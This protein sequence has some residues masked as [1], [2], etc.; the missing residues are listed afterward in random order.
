MLSP[1]KYY[2]RDIKNFLKDKSLSRFIILDHT[3]STTQD[4][5]KLIK[6]SKSDDK[7]V[8]V[9]SFNFLW[10]PL[11]T[12]ATNLGLRK[13]DNVEPNWLTKDDI[14]NLFYLENFEEIKRDNRFLIPID[15]GVISDIVNKF[16]A[17]LPLINDLCL[18]SYQIFKKVNHKKQ[19]SVSIIIPARNEEGN[20]KGILKKIPRIGTRLEVTFIEGGSK[21]NT[22]NAINKEIKDNKPSWMQATIYKQNGR[23]KNNAVKLGLSKAKN[24]ILMILDADLTVKPNELIKF[25]NA[26]SEGKGELIIG[27][28]LIYPME[29][30][31][32]RTLNYIGNKLFSVIFSF[33]I[34][35]RIKDTLCG[36]KVIL[37]KNYNLIVKGQKYFGNFDPFGDFD[38]IFGSAMLDLKITEIPVRYHDRKYGET[39]I[40]RFSHG[41][42]LLKMVF[43]GLLKLKF[44]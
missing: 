9:I 5:Q 24:E 4:I 34:G 30:Q 26:V 14:K 35:Q 22:F 42:L 17:R 16:I 31:A 43:I 3:L 27:S 40:S 32:M 6:K 1:S 38:F 21:D 29:K 41:L 10:K 13:K 11:L 36:T 7:K 37:S 25:Y 44:K 12:L 33:I 23:G 15:L 39:N 19:F 20:I 8:I 28:R 2:Q 18:T